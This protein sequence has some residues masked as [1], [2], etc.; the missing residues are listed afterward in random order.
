MA[1]ALVTGASSGIGLELARLLARDGHDIALVARGAAKLGEV[2][3]ELSEAYRVTATPLPV[4]LSHPGAA[5]ELMAALDGREID[6]LVNN[7]GFGAVG[8]F[9]E[10]ELAAQI[11][12]L[13][14][15]V[16]TLTELT[17]RLLPG[18][19]A[20]RRGRILNVASTAGFQPGPGMAVYYASK[21][22]VLSFSEALAVEVGGRGV[23][24]TA[25]APGVT[26]TGFQQR[27][28]ASEIL[29][30]RLG[31]MSAADVAAAGY[32]GML[33]GRALVVP[34]LVNKLGVQAVRVGPRWLVPR[35]VRHL[36]GV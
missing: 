17:G 16:V 11:A 20:R 23:S 12:M 19:L 30:T 7:A 22:Y 9:A 28:G 24:V 34:G 35:V 32:R 8:R 3:D 33:A 27:A 13:Q 2:A 1:V 25:L 29:L 4:D 18:M 10:T 26:E 36:H 21:A 14:L 15:N 31:G 5:A 6:V